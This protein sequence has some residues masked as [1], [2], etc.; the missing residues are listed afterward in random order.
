[1]K[2]EGYAD[3]SYEETPELVEA[4]EASSYQCALKTR[5]VFRLVSSEASL[6][7]VDLDDVGRYKGF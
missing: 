3:V 4:T 6:A 1:M 7:K 5:L 2:N